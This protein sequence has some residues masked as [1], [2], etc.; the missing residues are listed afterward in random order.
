MVDTLITQPAKSIGPAIEGVMDFFGNTVLMAATGNRQRVAK[1][2]RQ[3]TAVS[4]V[5][6]NVAIDA[7]NRVVQTTGAAM[8]PVKTASDFSNALSAD[9]AQE[10]VAKASG[11][12]AAISTIFTGLGEAEISGGAGP[13]R[14]GTQLTGT[15]TQAAAFGRRVRPLPG[16]HDVIVHGSPE[17]FWVYRGEEEIAIDQR[18][19]AT[20]MKSSEYGG[21]PVRLL[22]CKTGQCSA[23]IAQDLANKLGVEV[24]AP[25][26]SLWIWTNGEMT[27][28]PDEWTNTGTWNSFKPKPAR[29]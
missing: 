16:Y 10:I 8:H 11:P 18:R 15:D 19:L 23:A 4:M 7:S 25:S 29:R 9:E 28:G 26:D 3:V 13:A 6:A 1:F 22:S 2:N 27:I 24:L 14:L 12:T 5:P 20:Y 21:G 17:S